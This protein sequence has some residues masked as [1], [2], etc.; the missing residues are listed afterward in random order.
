MPAKALQGSPGR[1]LAVGTDPDWICE[2]MR[3]ES[4][5]DPDLGAVLGWCLDYSW[6]DGFEGRAPSIADQMTRMFGA[7]V[8]YVGE[9]EYVEA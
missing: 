6:A 3:I 4:T 2:Y 9:E 7:P 5:E 8:L 1:I